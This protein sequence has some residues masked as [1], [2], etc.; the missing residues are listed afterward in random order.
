MNPG[1]RQATIKPHI[2]EDAYIF[3]ATFKE[4]AHSTGIIKATSIF[5]FEITF[6]SSRPVHL[7]ESRFPKLAQIERG[8]EFEYSITRIM[9]Q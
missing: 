2:Y 1:E 6:V 7:S 3:A 5:S 9:R 4:R 8:K